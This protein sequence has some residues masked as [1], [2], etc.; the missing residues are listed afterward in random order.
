MDAWDLAEQVCSADSMEV[1]I[2]EY[3]R[4]SMPRAKS[5]VRFSHVSIAIAHSKGMMYWISSMFL[6]I[7]NF[8]IFR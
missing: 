2:R 1:A 8:V 6:R 3:D 7:V 4:L 5:T